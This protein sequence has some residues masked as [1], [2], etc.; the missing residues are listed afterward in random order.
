MTAAAGAFERWFLSD[1]AHPRRQGVVEPK[2]RA[3]PARTP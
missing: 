2:D 3:V 1:Q